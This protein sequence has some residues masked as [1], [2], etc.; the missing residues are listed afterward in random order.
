MIRHGLI[1]GLL[2]NS[3][4]IRCPKLAAKCRDLTITWARYSYHGPIIEDSSVDSIAKVA[5][6]SSARYCLML[7]Y[8]QILQEQWL[9]GEA[10]TSDL[11][12]QPHL[13]QSERF[14]VAG[15]VITE[16][17]GWYGLDHHCLLIDLESY[18]AF[19]EPS[20]NAPPVTTQALPSA[21]LISTHDGIAGLEPAPG[22]VQGRPILF[23]WRVIAESLRQSMPIFPVDR[24]LQKD[25]LDLSP[26]DTTSATL[27]SKYL[28]RG[29]DMYDRKSPE[30]GLSQDQATFLNGVSEQTRNARQGVFLLNIEPYIDVHAPPAQPWG[31]VSTLYSVAAGFKPNKI[32]QT[33]RFN[34][35]TKVVF[36]DY[37]SNA[38]QIRKTLVTEWD[39]DDFPRFVRYLFEQFPSPN[40]YYQL[41]ADRTPSNADWLEFEAFWQRELERFGGR[42]AFRDHWNEYRK[43]HHDFIRCDILGFPDELLSRIS[44]EPNAVIWFSNAPFTVYSN[45]HRT[46]AERRQA[47]ERWISGLA[48][49]N[50]AILL[51]G[52]DDSNTSVNC[53]SASAYWNRYKIVEHDE[54]NPCP[55]HRFQ[56]WS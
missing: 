5:V 17:E 32:L 19:G 45:W 37:S 48:Q 1:L 40:T 22:I 10:K 52:A 2:D 30:R 43:L 46:L 6:Q 54:L 36:F 50:P 44:P 16:N 38:L 11:H 33:H 12:A 47:Y 18:A 23:G 55:L 28:G 13:E 31:P 39:G 7:A 27:L 14:L 9:P 25:V 56:I 42:K 15:R 4:V 49:R 24:T 8:G 51:Y 20:F 26:E 29:I 35:N 21:R 34:E 53:I 41:W 3:S